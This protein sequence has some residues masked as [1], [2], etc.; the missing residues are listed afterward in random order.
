MTNSP[1]QSPSDTGVG[2]KVAVVTGAGRG[3]GKAVSLLLAKE[4]AAVV[5]ADVN[6]EWAR[7]VA[8][9]IAEVGGKS[10]AFAVDVSIREQVEALIEATTARFG[11]L[12]IVVNSAGI[13]RPARV[14]DLTEENWD[15]VLAVNLK[16]TF[17]VSQAALR[18][19]MGA[20]RGTIVNISSVSGK[21]GGIRSGVAYVASKGGV[22]SLTKALALEAAP[23]G[24]TVNTIAPGYIETDMLDVY[25]EMEREACKAGLVVDRVGTPEDIAQ[26][27]LYLVSDS[28]HYIT[29]TTLNINGGVFLD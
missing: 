9:E 8:D 2:D 1:K 6:P 12:E 7:R 22:I 15:N 25:S 16:G 14:M 5:C 27:V 11:R 20:R 21:T 4:G 3:I 28:G 17:L 26:G 13:L 10:L 18:P 19:M 23:Y 29:G 24:I